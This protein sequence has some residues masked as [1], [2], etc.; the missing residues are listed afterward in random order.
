MQ[1]RVRLRGGQRVWLNCVHPRPPVAGRERRLARARRGAAAR[2]QAR[3]RTRRSP[4]SCAETS[5]TSRGRSTTRL[6]QKVSRL[7]DPRKGRGVLQ[8]LPRALS[9][10]SATRSTTCSTPTT[11]GSCRCGGSAYVGSDHFPVFVELSHEPDGRRGAGGADARDGRRPARGRARRCNDARTERL[12]PGRAGRRAAGRQPSV[13]AG[14]VLSGESVIHPGDTPT[15]RPTVFLRSSAAAALAAA[16]ITTPASAQD[17]TPRDRERESLRPRRLTPAGTSA[18]G[19]PTPTTTAP[20]PRRHAR[21]GARSPTRPACASSRSPTDGPAAKAGVEEGDRIVSIDGTS[22]RV[23]RA[24]TPRTRR[25]ATSRAPPAARAREAQGRRRGLARAAARPRDAHGAREDGRRR[26]TCR[27]TAP[28]AT[29]FGAR[30][31][32][33]SLRAR[34]RARSTTALRA[35]AERRPAL[36]LTVGTTGEPARHARPVRAARSRP[37]ARPRRRASSRARASRAIDGVDVRVPREDAEDPRSRRCASRRFTRELRS[38]TPGR[39]RRAARVAERRATA[40]SRVKAGTRRRRVQGPQRLLASRSATA[41]ASLV[42]P[43]MPRTPGGADRPVP[44]MAPAAPLD[45]AVPTRPD[46]R[47]AGCAAGP[48]TPPPDAPRPAVRAAR[49]CVDGDRRLR[50]VASAQSRPARPERAHGTA[51]CAGS[52]V[53]RRPARRFG[54]RA[55]HMRVRTTGPSTIAFS[56][57]LS[58]ARHQPRNIGS[59]ANSTT[60]PRAERLLDHERG[61]AEQRARCCRARRSRRGRS[62]PVGGNTATLVPVARRA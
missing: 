11:S 29:A 1:A 42:M 47:L 52:D 41:T 44:P 49:A 38:S 2:R 22:L 35:R 8:H 5:T 12:Q 19:A 46:R 60:W 18:S 14:R 62:A 32:R 45:P 37:T 4:W 55:V 10:A 16:A 28:T 21:A 61:V 50:T 53:R 3:R 31:H 43:S 40:P 51:G 24:R 23:D 9:R 48:R 17:T 15:M 33:D 6:F 36:G 20:R 25:S 56:T 39:R 34:R 26:R 54:R 30:G 59:F 57:S 13:E 27:A 7:V 58:S